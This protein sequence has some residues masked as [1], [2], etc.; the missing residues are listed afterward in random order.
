MSQP[1]VET[2][3]S[4]T[5]P[6]LSLLG[7][8]P[9]DDDG[10]SQPIPPLPP[11]LDTLSDPMSRPA[12]RPNSIELGRAN[13]PRLPSSVAFQKPGKLMIV[14]EKLAVF[15]VI[16]RQLEHCGYRSFVVT[17]D[18][19]QVMPLVKSEHP[20]LI[21]IDISMSKA[22]GLEVLRQLRADPHTRYL[23]VLVVTASSDPRVKFEALELGASDFLPKPFDIS[24]LAPRVR[25][26]LLLKAHQDQLAR[27]ADDLERQVRTRT[28]ELEVSR[29]EIIQCLARAGEYR[30][31]ETGNH[32]VRVGKYA[33]I[34][35]RELNLPSEDVALIEQAALLHDVG[36]IGVSDLILL[37]P[38]KLTPEEFALMKKH[39]EFGRN[40]IQPPAEQTSRAVRQAAVSSPIMDMAARIAMTHHEWWNGSGYPR[41]L[42]GVDI[43]LEGRIT[44]LADVFDALSSPRPYK[45]AYPVEA[46]FEI[47]ARNRGTQFDPR[48]YDAFVSARAAILQVLQDFPDDAGAPDDPRS[49][50]PCLLPSGSPG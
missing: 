44:A 35:A 4:P 12:G 7:S 33:A 18:P 5:V 50:D 32:V 26:A 20:D 8:R 31:H 30:D 25:N 46:C 48:A 17:S 16:Q 41:G 13:S 19:N 3:E 6:G 45:P 24:D 15:A 47:M 2:T 9:S 22:G 49:T 42:A 14:D 40:I 36:K 39:C 29:H 38:G 10:T 1:F 27:N 37:K 23:P 34:I 21:L 11:Q 28:D 43:P